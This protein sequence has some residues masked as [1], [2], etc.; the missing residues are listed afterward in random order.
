MPDTAYESGPPRRLWKCYPTEGL[1]GAGLEPNRERCGGITV[2]DRGGCELSVL[3]VPLRNHADPLPLLSPGER[4]LGVLV[5]VARDGAAAA[6]ERLGDPRHGHAVAPHLLGDFEILRSED[7]VAH[8]CRLTSRPI[9]HGSKA[10]KTIGCSS[11]ARSAG[12]ILWVASMLGTLGPCGR[13]VKCRS[14]HARAPGCSVTAWAARPRFLLPRAPVTSTEG[15]RFVPLPI[16]GFGLTAG[17]TYATN[18]AR[19]ARARSGG[20]ALPICKN[21]LPRAPA[22]LNPPGYD[23]RSAALAPVI[24]TEP[25]AFCRGPSPALR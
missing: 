8:R 1:D 23:C 16:T 4:L 20:T 17:Y 9:I 21:C 5:G 24:R 15:V 13:G 2:S 12:L 7:D 25:G 18:S 22:N 6:A 14:G 19:I 11:D 10:S 3:G